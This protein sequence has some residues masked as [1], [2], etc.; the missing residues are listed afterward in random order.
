MPND[1]PTSEEINQ[2][3]FRS[4]LIALGA[5]AVPL[6]LLC[7]SA[8]AQ[9]FIISSNGAAALLVNGTVSVTNSVA[10]SCSPFGLGS[11]LQAW[12]PCDVI[13]TGTTPDATGNGFTGSPQS[14]PTVVTGII[15]N[16]ISFASPQYVDTTLQNL[17]FS[18]GS[19]TCWAFNTIAFNNNGSVDAFFGQ[20]FGGAS[21]LQFLKFT[22][23]N[24]YMGWYNGGTDT[25]L[26]VAA[27]SS[28]FPESVWAMYALVWSASGTSAYVY[29]AANPTGLLIG[30]NGSVPATSNLGV[31]FQF[32]GNFATGQ[33]SY[34]GNMDD[35]QVQNIALTTTQ[36]QNQYNAGLG[37]C[38]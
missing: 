32:G 30:S 34:T 22:D 17:N 11:S 28:N 16:A 14:S 7:A 36:L 27:S 5:W 24:L 38:P 35:V 12:W 1:N 19:I 37:G 18:S 33:A 20:N 25:R 15:T 8:N 29:D 2:W 31:D 10:A 9:I 4:G 26:V 3:W 21:A 13:T 23:G 6:L